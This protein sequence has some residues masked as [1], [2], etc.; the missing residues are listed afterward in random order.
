MSNSEF[1]RSMLIEQR[2]RLV[3]S[4]M[5]YLETNCYPKLK[6]HERRALRDKVLAS[7]GVYHDTCLD[8]LKASVN[9]G[10]VINEA[11][12]EA[13][14]RVHADVNKLLRDAGHAG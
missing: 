10:S 3:G 8:M 4:L 6:D 13:I 1:V 5:E 14:E 9:D 11:A 2:K 12:L 7:V